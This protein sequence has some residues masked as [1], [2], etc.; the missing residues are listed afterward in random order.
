MT[1][2]SVQSAESGLV[3]AVTRPL[4]A[5]L[6]DGRRGAVR[7]TR[8]HNDAPCWDAAEGRTVVAAARA[9]ALAGSTT[10]A[11]VLVAT[12]V[13]TVAYAELGAR[14]APSVL[15]GHPATAAFDTASIA[16]WLRGITDTVA[17]SGADLYAEA[18]LLAEAVLAH[19]DTTEG[20]LAEAWIAVCGLTLLEELAES[21]ATPDAEAR[22]IQ[23]TVATTV[24][25]RRL[26]PEARIARL[27]GVD[28]Q[29]LAQWR[30]FGP[31]SPDIRGHHISAPLCA[32]LTGMTGPQWRALYASGRVP[33]AHDDT[34]GILSWD[35]GE[36]LRWA[37]AHSGEDC[38]RRCCHHQPV[39]ARVAVAAGPAA[40]ARGAVASGTVRPVR[41]VLV[42]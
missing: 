37:T 40:T 34:H 31:P 7:R 4:G 19:P 10:D 15:A 27:T 1:L 22:L 5:L 39:A 2:R 3:P 38:R 30:R 32:A 16:T 25:A 28:R 8:L 18:R 41:L 24:V 11:R 36:V 23:R 35:E 20:V 26:A 17:D 6:H 9:A 13:A 29:T 14:S 21:S 42:R 12:M 33:D